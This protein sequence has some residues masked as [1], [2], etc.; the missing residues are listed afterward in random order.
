MAYVSKVS[1]QIVRPRCLILP[2]RL[3][4]QK[5]DGARIEMVTA[6]HDLHLALLDAFREYGV[7][8]LELRHNILRVDVDGVA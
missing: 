1:L 7:R 6:G 5:L 2:L 4:V 8:R 3:I